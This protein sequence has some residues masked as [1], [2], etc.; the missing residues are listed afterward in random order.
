MDPNLAHLSSA[1]SLGVGL[2]G[3]MRIWMWIRISLDLAS[4]GVDPQPTLGGKWLLDF[5][6]GR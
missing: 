1:R 4:Q 2:D 5:Y 3:A 6:P